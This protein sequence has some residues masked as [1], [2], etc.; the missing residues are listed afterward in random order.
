MALEKVG[1]DMTQY[2]ITYYT[3]P[4]SV[5]SRQQVMVKSL[6]RAESQAMYTYNRFHEH[7]PV[8][9]WFKDKRGEWE[10][11]ASNED[12]EELI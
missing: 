11:I 8:H 1:S 9:I 7:G 2:K 10:I 12:I 6:A 4:G 5:L 3:V